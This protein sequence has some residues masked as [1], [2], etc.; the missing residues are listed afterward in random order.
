MA[1][2]FGDT[3]SEPS[4]IGEVTQGLGFEQLPVSDQPVSNPT[5][6]INETIG[7]FSTEL[8]QAPTGTGASG[9]IMINFGVGGNTTGDEFTMLPNGV[10]GPNAESLGLEYKFRIGL[11]LSRSSSP[12]VSILLLRFMYADDGII[13]NAIQVSGSFSVQIDNANTTWR[14]VFDV[15]FTPTIGSVSFIEF[16]RDEAGDDSGELNAQQPTGTLNSWSPVASARYE[17]IKQTVV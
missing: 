12:G 2:L 15:N 1:R 13:E 11:R 10:V 5:R 7:A 6:I 16:A 17:I 4:P 14:E 9:K 8:S 3:Q